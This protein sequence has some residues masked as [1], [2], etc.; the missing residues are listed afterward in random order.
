MEERKKARAVRAFEP[1]VLR[2]YER[3]I[4]YC[5][6]GRHLPTPFKA[7]SNLDERY[8]LKF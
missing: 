5:L 8:K 4:I 1:F 6:S 3:N 2:L 7:S